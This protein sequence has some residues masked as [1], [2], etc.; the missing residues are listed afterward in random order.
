MIIIIIPEEEV[1]EYAELFPIFDK[2]KPHIEH[3]FLF[4]RK[5]FIGFYGPN[6]LLKYIILYN[7]KSSFL[8]VVMLFRIM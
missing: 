7:L 5:E 8:E 4:L 6:H 1:N 2:D 3:S